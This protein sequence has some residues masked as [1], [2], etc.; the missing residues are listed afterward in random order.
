MKDFIIRDFKVNFNK[1]ILQL[2]MIVVSVAL[3]MGILILHG[4][5][6]K[7]ISIMSEKTGLESMLT[8]TSDELFDQDII[9]QAENMD[10]VVQVNPQL[11][12]NSEGVIHEDFKSMWLLG[13]TEQS[14]A[15]DKLRITKGRTIN[16][17]AKK[18]EM[19]VDSKVA[20]KE[21]LSV[22]DEIT[23]SLNTENTTFKVVGIYQ[24]SQFSMQP[25]YEFYVNGQILQE[26]LN[27]VGQ[28]NKINV[29]TSNQNFQTVSR[30]SEEVK[31][32]MG[33]NATCETVIERRENAERDL[34]SFSMIL[35]AVLA[36][37]ILGS[38]YLIYS[39][40]SLRMDE[41][42]KTIAVFKTLGAKEKQIK[43]AFIKEGMLIGGIG[44]V[45]GVIAGIFVGLCLCY[46]YAERDYWEV[47]QYFVIKIMYVIGSIFIA[48]VVCYIGSVRPIRRIAKISP[49]SALKNEVSQQQK[50]LSM[51]T[52]V[53]RFASGLTLLVIVLLLSSQAMYIESEG[54]IYILMVFLGLNCV[55]AMFL[56]IPY[57][58]TLFCK[59]IIW[60][61]K[62]KDRVE[63]YLATQN[64]INNRNNSMVILS[65]IVTGI[66][67]IAS[68]HGM[69][70]SA[71]ESV[72]NYA[73]HAFAHDYLIDC[74]TKDK[75]EF[76]E[77]VKSIE[78]TGMLKDYTNIQV[79]NYEDELSGKVLR[80]FG[81]DPEVYND[82]ST[83]KLYSN[84]K[85]INFKDLA[86]DQ[87]KCFVS[88][89]IMIENGYHLGDTIKFKQGGEH[90]E[91]TV[92]AYFNSFT[93]GGRLIYMNQEQLNLLNKDSKS[94]LFCVN[95]KNQISSEAFQDAIREALNGK[96]FSLLSVS[97][98]ASTWKN[99]VIKGT[100]VFYLIFAMITVFVIS[101]LFNNYITSIL[102]RKREVGM[103]S[104]LGARRKSIKKIF[105]IEMLFMY[106]VA[107]L[108]GGIGS[109][110]TLYIFVQC[111]SAV[112]HADLSVYYPCEIMMISG[113]LLIVVFMLLNLIVI[114]RILKTN[115]V[116]LIKERTI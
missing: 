94:S 36:I 53:I 99:D 90:F 14:L 60:I 29:V 76:N 27:E 86:S 58:M 83:L 12:Y 7:R 40:F 95:K 55:L 110:V 41:R 112:F 73:L 109:Y 72:E 22:G 49:I 20:A 47:R 74:E 93:N 71:R 67:I 113:V 64:L 82:Y 100:E 98:F 57:I 102:Q 107:L 23:V 44:G 48:L 69:F 105:M 96:E 24:R 42:I 111:L 37:L 17:S 66:M 13:V 19:L 61:L 89:Q 101:S 31:A 103:L 26:K 75:E 84:E 1:S 63:L 11:E 16:F 8:V 91:L 3:T 30:I 6:S 77:I 88:H 33:E 21:N 35:W 39:T 28:F 62:G 25:C 104:S 50:K 51:K 2:F 97:E 38:T 32:L 65:I 80:V 54:L 18:L 68:L 78:K 85:G 92:A 34:Q 70:S 52:Q 45:L 9:E 10:D 114:K 5:M 79:Y 43:S 87:K 46:F 4:T 106:L 108:V 116:Q 115:E 15:F 56:I 59:G 81:V